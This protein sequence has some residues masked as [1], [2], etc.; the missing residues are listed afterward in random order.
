M[1]QDTPTWWQKLESSPSRVVPI[2]FA[3]AVAALLTLSSELLARHLALFPLVRTVRFWRA[4]AVGSVVLTLVPERWSRYAQSLVLLGLCLV[5]DALVQPAT[6][7]IVALGVVLILTLPLESARF[8]KW[9]VAVVCVLAL[10][11]HR[12]LGPMQMIT[13]FQFVFAAE[14]MGATGNRSWHDRCRVML[15]LGFNVPPSDLLLSS[16]SLL[17]RVEGVAFIAGGVLLSMLG[18]ELPARLLHLTPDWW[19]LDLVIRKLGLIG[20]LLGG[21]LAFSG[22]LRVA[23]VPVRSAVGDLL[24]ARNILEFWATANTWR[25]EMFRSVF[26]KHFFR[27]SPDFRGALAIVGVFGVSAILHLADN[28]VAWRMAAAWLAIGV[29]AALTYAWKVHRLLSLETEPAAEPS[30][31]GR[32]GRGLV[33][34]ASVAAL[35]VFL[36]TAMGV[37]RGDL[38]AG[39]TPAPRH[40][41]PAR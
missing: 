34:V 32:A 19:F 22:A 7:V 31:L 27:I 17:P 28:V 15:P 21:F 12:Y 33:D 23:G 5:S 3:L 9:L 14:V 25:Y 40:A 4:L 37:A 13:L 1:A 16:R 35:V 11:I 2:V 26:V 39:K 38:Q 18:V 29:V 24:A 20:R 8:R 41:R 36:V 30:L 6:A 10:A